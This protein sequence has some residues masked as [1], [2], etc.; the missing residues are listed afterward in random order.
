M[1]FE[2]VPL[3]PAIGIEVR[4]IDLAQPLDEA[5]FEPI[6]CAWERHCV[7]LVRGQDIT[8][9][10]QAQFASRFGT[11]TRPRRGPPPVL[12]VSNARSTFAKPAVLP[13]GPV[14]F[15][16]DQSYLAEPSIATVL[17]AMDVPA[18]GGNTI[19]ASGLRAYDALPE[20]LKRRLAHCE[21]EHAYDQLTSPSR[22][23][24]HVPEGWKHAVHPVFR[25]HPPTGR[26]AIY[27]SRLMT[28]SIV[29]MTSEESRQTLDML[30]DHQERAEFSYEHVWRPGDLVVWDNRSCIH[31]RTDF[32]PAEPRRLRRM[33]VLDE[34]R[35]AA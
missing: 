34:H 12:Y 20:D 19:F 29:G 15:H 22:R 27:V 23:P 13:A 9:E 2:I 7:L 18:K 32:D 8:Q 30:F 5:S 4:G 16:S 3:S 25:V 1:Q 33:T 28:R 17:Y 21:A 6:G 14:D 26:T 10:Q 35:A 24:E 11:L 31:A